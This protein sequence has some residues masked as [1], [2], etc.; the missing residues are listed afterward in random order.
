MGVYLLHTSDMKANY[1]ICT[2]SKSLGTNM[3]Y[4]SVESSW[5]ESAQS[6]ILHVAAFLSFFLNN[7]D[8]IQSISPTGY[9]GKT[10]LQPAHPPAH[11]H[12]HSPCYFISW[13]HNAN[14]RIKS[15][16][17]RW[18]DATSIS[19]SLAWLI[20]SGYLATGLVICDGCPPSWPLIIRLGWMETS[21]VIT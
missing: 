2:M 10:I 16:S 9:F 21:L 13:Q 19:T 8:N 18:N 1:Y 12:T 14:S 6:I 20:R 7:G 11:T 5:S 15:L 17:F 3:P 4:W